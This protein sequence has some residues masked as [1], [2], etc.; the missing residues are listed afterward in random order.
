MLFD[1]GASI[2]MTRQVFGDLPMGSEFAVADDRPLASSEA[3]GQHRDRNTCNTHVE[4][5]VTEY[6][7]YFNGVTPVTPQHLRSTYWH[8]RNLQHVH[9]A[10]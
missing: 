1:S 5:G 9:W 7:S 2:R 4:L 8:G 6:R 10:F 3:R